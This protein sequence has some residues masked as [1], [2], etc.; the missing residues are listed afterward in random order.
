[1]AE[2]I[3]QEEL[4]QALKRVGIYVRSGAVYDLATFPAGLAYSLFADAAQHREP[5]YEDE[6]V[7]ADAYGE[8][9]RY[10]EANTAEGWDKPAWNVFGDAG[11]YGFDT[12]K[13]PLRKI[14]PEGN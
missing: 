3:T 10:Y 13:R 5:E 9:W 1:M 14:W 7:Y 12:P 8:L 2:T 11:E 6:A 4:E